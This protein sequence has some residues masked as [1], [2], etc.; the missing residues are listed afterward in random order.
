M[1]IESEK[2]A[3]VI[4]PSIA[5]KT[6]LDCIQSVHDQTYS[7]IKHLVVFDGG[8]A[9]TKASNL[10]ISEY[11]I[12]LQTTV[13]PE[14]TGNSGG[15][16]WGHRI[17]A[18]YAHLINA[19]YV[20]F[21]D[22]DNFYEPNH[23]ETLIDLIE[24]KKLEWAYSLRNIVSKEGDFIIEDCC[25]SLG[26]WPIYFTQDKE[27]KDFLVDTSAYCFRRDFLI[28]VAQH[29]HHGWGADRL[30]YR[31]ITKLLKHKNFNTTGL[32]TLNYRLDDN[33]EK[34]YGSI[35]FFKN[36]NNA[37]KQYYGGYPWKH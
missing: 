6:L 23:V 2:K 24:R 15:N 29:W 1:K 35:D 3:C 27:E 22:E 7:N 5:N 28:R 21:L 11:Y 36:G 26:K 33:I 13:T 32:H 25:E 14:N 17:Y 37:T 10:Q 9:L 34:K 19:D 18:G 31:I 20:F 16:F 30:F 12:K 8:E 4:T